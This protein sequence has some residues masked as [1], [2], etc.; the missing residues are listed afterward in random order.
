MAFDDEEDVRGNDYEKALMLDEIKRMKPVVDVAVALHDECLSRLPE[1][2]QLVGSMRV[3]A[4]V[5]L[6]IDR[7][8]FYKKSEEKH[9]K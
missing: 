6:L 3:R 9:G 8:N 2:P 4:L 7:V 1:L 5:E